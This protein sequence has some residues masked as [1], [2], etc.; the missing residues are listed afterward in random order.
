MPDPL[1]VEFDR[2]AI[3][4]PSPGWRWGLCWLMFASTVLCYMDRQSMTLVG[5]EIKAE[6]HIQNEGFG[7]VLAAF[8]LTYAF[9]QVPAGYL[10]DR[11]DVRG[12]YAL[13]VIWWSLSAAALAFAPTLGMLMVFRALLG[14]GESFNWPCALRATSAVLPPADRG[15]GN[16][17]FNS[18]AAVG[19][20]LTPWI[21]TPLSARYGWRP[22]F[23]IVASMGG[24]WVVAWLAMI[25]GPHRGLLAGRGVHELPPMA[26]AGVRNRGL[27]RAA[28]MTFGI[29]VVLSLL[30]A[31]LSRWF[32]T[33]AIWW[34]IASFMFGLLISA[35]VLPVEALKGA[36][37]AESLGD[38][39]R[40]RRFWV[41]VLVSC[42]INVCWHFLI[43]WLPTYLKEDR[44]MT[45][46][47]SGMLSS[48]PFLAADFG[49][50]GGGAFSRALASRGMSP[51]VAR[52]RVMAGCSLLIA[53]GA[54]VG[55]IRDDRLAIVLLGVMALGTAAF[56]ANY[57]AF[58]QEVSGRHTG[59]VV[60]VLGGLGN[61]FVAGFL[62]F[63]GHV[64]DVSG[65]FGGIFLIAGLLPFVGL[66]ALLIGWRA[67][68]D[69]V[70]A[71]AG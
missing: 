50:L 61:L 3:S 13:A 31:S 35:R 10:A 40:L 63:A 49:N 48:L 19:A 47:A 44:G 42:S 71:E 8:S 11:C 66:G 32:G 30:V 9:F 36:D 24:I 68:H 57:F 27:S 55:L 62:P 26:D 33:M 5:S 21:V 15:L 46:L 43:N 70:E 28:T 38:I 54:L 69:G 53:S 12:I 4:K 64:K 67:G 45:Y 25:R 23:I 7:W 51:P 52:L 56:M 34:A 59:L 17:I 14:F 6:F 29:L 58:C 22:T 18:G 2:V 60:G 16:G 37:W 65:S 1:V 39:V 20:V 41:L